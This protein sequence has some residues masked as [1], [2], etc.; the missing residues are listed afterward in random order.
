MFKSHIHIQK[1]K[2]SYAAMLHLSQIQF[3]YL[4]QDHSYLSQPKEYGWSI[5]EDNLIE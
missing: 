1:K 2:T 5:C 3:L 4:I